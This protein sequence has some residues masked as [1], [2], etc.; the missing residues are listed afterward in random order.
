[1]RKFLKFTVIFLGFLI[2]ILFC[3]TIFTIYNK[4][5]NNGLKNLTSLKLEPQIERF[6]TIKDFQLQKNLIHFR[7][8]NI[9]DNS[10]YIR[11]YN[12]K[13]GKLSTEIKIK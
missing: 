1:M 10:Q 11:T 3:I 13:N 4:Y 7:L 12:L 8:E 6:L 9:N 2:V 5:N